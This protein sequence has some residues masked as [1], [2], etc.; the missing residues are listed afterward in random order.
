MK[1]GGRGE[2]AEKHQGGRDPL[3]GG[4]DLKL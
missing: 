4:C 3:D 2:N 1:H